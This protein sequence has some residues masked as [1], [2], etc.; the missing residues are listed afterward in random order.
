MCIVWHN[1][2]FF[3]TD[4]GK[5]QEVFEFKI[6]QDLLMLETSEPLG[7][8]GFGKVFKTDFKGNPVAVKVIKT[9]QDKDAKRIPLTEGRLLR[10]DQELF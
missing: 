9:V 7:Q 3:F 1:Y 6:S 2:Y 5:L 4:K 8:G 10:Y